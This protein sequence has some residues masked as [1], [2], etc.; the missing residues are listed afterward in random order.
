MA[1]EPKTWQCGE[2]V[3]ADAL[4]HLEQG[5]A[6]AGGSAMIVRMSTEG[7]TDKTWQQVY[8]ALIGGTLVYVLSSASSGGTDVV[9]HASILMAVGGH[10]S[11]IATMMSISHDG[12]SAQATSLV[13]DSADG[14]LRAMTG[15]TGGGQ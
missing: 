10:N 7:T 2:V 11:Y 14:Y 1:Y 5:V 12:T 13:A 6:N 4:N 3:S 15:G 9:A 8:D